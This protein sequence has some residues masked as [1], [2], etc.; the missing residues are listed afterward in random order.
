MVRT[1]AVKIL[2]MVPI[3]S[4]SAKPLTSPYPNSY[5][6]TP[7]ISVVTCESITVVSARR[8]P[9]AVATRIVLPF[10]TSS[11][12]LEKMITFASTAIPIVR[13]IPAIPGRVSTFLNATSSQ[14]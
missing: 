11:L 14:R 6:A 5:R 10:L 13:I 3:M 12:I 2:S 1:V 8:Y 9:W 7:A 4:V